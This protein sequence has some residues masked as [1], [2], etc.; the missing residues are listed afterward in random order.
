MVLSQYARYMSTDG[1]YFDIPWNEQPEYWIDDCSVTWYR[2]A[3]TAQ[4]YRCANHAEP[5]LNEF[6]KI[7]LPAFQVAIR[8][9]V[10]V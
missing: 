3:I 2:V 4:E 7:N 6:S 5:E 1:R 10:Y 9:G 8:L